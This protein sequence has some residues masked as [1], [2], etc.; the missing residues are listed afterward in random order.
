MSQ[1][2]DLRYHPM[3]KDVK[4]THLTIADDL[5]IFCKGEEL[6]VLRI[7]EAL[8]HFLDVTSLNANSDKSSIYVAGVEEETENKLL[9]ITRFKIGTFPVKYL[10]LPLSPKKWNKLD[11]HQLVLKITK[12]IRAVLARHLS[13]AGKLQ[14]ITSIL[15][16][17][18]NFWG[19]VF[20]LPQSV[21]KNVD[22]KCR[23]FLWGNNEKDKKMALV[24]WETVCKPKKEGG[25]NIKSSKKWNLAFVGKVIW[26][27]VNNKELLWVKWIYGIYMKQNDDFCTHVPPSSSSWYWKNPNKI[28]LGM[29][30]CYNNGTCIL[31]TIGKYSVNQS[32]LDILG[33]GAS[34]GSYDL[35]WSKILLPKH[36]FI[37]WL[38]YQKRLL[39]K[40]RMLGMGFQCDDA[41]CVLC[42]KQEVE[43][44]C[45]ALF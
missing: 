31:T 3:C 28:K 27:L 26:L 15:F 34:M 40:D 7:M 42:K 44:N 9:E 21:L 20:I 17:L 23:D 36:R 25:L 37:L 35:I 38:A 19:A 24:S 18:H 12:K 16:S 5:M 33:Q 45:Y 11:C 43:D 14:V 2:T 13:Y 6:S 30:Q 41:H 29:Q 22:K 1:L 32:Y 4:L 8:R 39:T 10:G